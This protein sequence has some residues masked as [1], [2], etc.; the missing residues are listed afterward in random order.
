MPATASLQLSLLYKTVVLSSVNDDVV[1]H[2]DVHHPRGFLDSFGELDVC[3]AGPDVARWVVVAQHYLGGLA[4]NGLLHD[5]ARVHLG[6]EMPPLLI[7]QVF[8]IR[9]AWLRY[10]VQNSSCSR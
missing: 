6:G 5:D 4:Q 1:H 10:I 2:I 7:W 8:R 9:L 3:A